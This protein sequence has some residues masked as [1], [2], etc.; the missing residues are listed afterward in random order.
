MNHAIT[1]TSGRLRRRGTLHNAPR[2]SRCPRRNTDLDWRCSRRRLESIPRTSADAAEAGAG[3][4]RKFA[5]WGSPGKV[6]TP[7]I[8]QVEDGSPPA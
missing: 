5:T 1:Y 8:D 7:S 2:S 3:E 4:T 6:S